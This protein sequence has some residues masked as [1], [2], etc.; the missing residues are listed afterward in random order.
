MYAL[1]IKNPPMTIQIN[2][3]KLPEKPFENANLLISVER[4]DILRR[5][6]NI[7]FEFILLFE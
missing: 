3:K 4:R 1:Y 6:M 7:Q 2:D 5:N